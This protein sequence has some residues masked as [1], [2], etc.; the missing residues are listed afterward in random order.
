MDAV[1]NFCQKN[2]LIQVTYRLS[3]GLPK[4]QTEITSQKELFDLS[5]NSM[6]NIENRKN[7]NKKW[8]SEP[9]SSYHKTLLIFLF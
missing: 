8:S 1:I 7:K 4:S 9:K 6:R 5:T 3:I 2:L